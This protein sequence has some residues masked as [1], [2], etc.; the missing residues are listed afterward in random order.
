MKNTISI[1]A[2][3]SD[4]FSAHLLQDGK[5]VGEYEGYVPSFFPGE[6]YGDY[7]QFN[8]DADTGQIINWKRPTQR[9]L[10]K[11]FSKPTID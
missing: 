4:L 7:I 1:N 2:K 10:L 3:C 11:T 6:H 5:I 9:D 8:I